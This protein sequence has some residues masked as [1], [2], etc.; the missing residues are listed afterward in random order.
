MSSVAGSTNGV[1]S[2]ET[3]RTQIPARLD[4][5]PWSRW[6]WTVVIALGITWIL[7]GLEVTIVGAV[8]SVLTSRATLHLTATQ[9]GWAA[10][11]YIMG[12]VTGSLF[13]GFLTDRLGRK[14]LF[15]VT[16]AVYLVA[17]LLTAFSMNFVMFVIFRFFTGTGIGGEYSAVNSAVDELIPAR[18]RGWADLAING[19]Y[20]MGTIVGSLLT[21]FLLNPRLVP[22]WLG[23]RLAFGIGPI[24]AVGILLVRRYV[25]E[26]PRW[27]MTHDRINEA[28]SIVSDIEAKVKREDHLKRLPKPGASITIHTRKPIGFMTLVRTMF[29][30]YPT[31]SVLGFALMTGQAFLYNAI[32]FTYAL[33]L[34]AFYAVPPDQ[35]G[36]YLIAFAAG[37]LMGPLL[38]G[39]LFD[40]IGRRVM[41]S[42]TYIGSGVLLLLTAFLFRA[43]ILNAVTQT[44]AWTIIF[45]FASAGASAAYL[46]VSEVFPL[47]IRALAIAF[48]YSIGTGA[49]GIVGPVLFGS[50]IATGSRD[51]LF[52]GY[53]IGAVVMAAAGV[54]EIFLGVNAERESLENI[55]TPLSAAPETPRGQAGIQAAGI[56]G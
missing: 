14:K 56:G 42:S 2:L 25:P 40:T 1:P 4:R 49:G 35:I 34:Q 15:M 52:V 3:V 22:T 13:F 19:S 51:A 31:R 7:D 36:Y 5:L 30:T 27:L 23:W 20:W 8:A 55:A 44:V 33:V 16:L 17:T 48:F 54:V 11:I 24:L 53:I 6:H 18:V 10:A 32:F 39:R 47:E 26:S 29:G 28:N 21:V 50:L 37:N 12:A 43:G 45:F 46:T 41:I 38:L 9:I